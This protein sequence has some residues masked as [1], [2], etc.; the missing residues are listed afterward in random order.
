MNTNGGVINGD[1][2]LS[3]LRNMGEVFG[4][5]GSFSDSVRLQHKDRKWLWLNNRGDVYMMAMP[6]KGV[7]V[8]TDNVTND[9]CMKEVMTFL[10]ANN[11]DCFGD[12]YNKTII[13]STTEE[14][15]LKSIETVLECANV[16]AGVIRSY[17]TYSK[18]TKYYD[19]II[20]R[21]NQKSI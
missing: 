10:N 12:D 17:Q 9:K 1:T 16:M 18:K 4:I 7:L 8:I 2:F 14:L 13:Y 21:I 6:G 5:E 20:A 11:H 19:W 3:Y 15:G